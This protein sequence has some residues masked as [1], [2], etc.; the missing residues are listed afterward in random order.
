MNTC[1]LTECQGKPR[2]APCTAMDKRY[3]PPADQAEA[4]QL[5][6]KAVGDY[7]SACRMASADRVAMGNYLMKLASVTGCMMANAEGADTAFDRLLGTARFV[8][9]TMPKK[10]AT[11]H[12]VQ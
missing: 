6:K 9:Q 4:E 8:L 11:L 12:P 7:L 2:C 3:G 5:A 1:K 10:P